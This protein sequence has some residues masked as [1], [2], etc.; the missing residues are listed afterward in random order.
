MQTTLA[1]HTLVIPARTE[2]GKEG[3]REKERKKTAN[4]F[5]VKGQLF[6]AIAVKGQIKGVSW[7]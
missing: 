1:W 6:F 7:V 5:W 2:K 4:I 3:Q